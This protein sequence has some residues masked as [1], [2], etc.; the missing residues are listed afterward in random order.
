MSAKTKGVT[1]PQK[2]MTREDVVRLINL[3]HAIN[4]IPWWKR[5]YLKA[6]RRFAK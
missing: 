3:Y 1:D 6:K 2:L 5:L 4:H